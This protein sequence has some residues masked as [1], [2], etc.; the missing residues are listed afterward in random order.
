MD[1]TDNDRHKR[2]SALRIAW[3]LNTFFVWALKSWRIVTILL[4]FYLS[5][6]VALIGNKEKLS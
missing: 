2:P 1:W 5:V 4:K 6:I 3:L